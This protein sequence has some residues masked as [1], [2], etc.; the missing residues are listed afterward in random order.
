MI[1]DT[2]GLSKKTQKK[3]LLGLLLGRVG[4]YEGFFFFV[5][6]Y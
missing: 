6:V 5:C 4:C 2:R 3:F 1:D